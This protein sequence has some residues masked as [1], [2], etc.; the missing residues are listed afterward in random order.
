MKPSRLRDL[1]DVI[2]PGLA[3]FCFLIAIGAI[4]G[5]YFNYQ[6]QAEEQERRASAIA[7]IL[8]CFDDYAS[9]SATTSQAVRDAS[10][11]VSEATT[12]RDVAL[13]R[14]FVYIATDPP[15]GTP[16]GRDIFGRLLDSNAE[17]VKAQRMLATVRAENPV[18]DPPS[19]FCDVQP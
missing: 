8:S 6:I 13:D 16:Q 14:L 10:V 4:V 1:Y 19:T 12:D 11:K 7:S 5:T 18:P 15:E 3:L 17:L 9:A 2:A